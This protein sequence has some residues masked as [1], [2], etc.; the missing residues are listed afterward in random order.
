MNDMY[1]MSKEEAE[2]T[3]VAFLQ[4]II[5]ASNYLFSINH[6]EPYSYEG[7]ACGWLRYH[8][9]VEFLTCALNINKDNENKTLALTNYA[10]KIGI[11]IKGIKFGRS[12]FDYAADSVE[13]CIYKGL[14]GIKF[15]N[16][17]VSRELYALRNNHYSSAIALF[18]DILNN[19]SIN[20]RQMDILI[21]LGFFEDY[22]QPKKLLKQLEIYNESY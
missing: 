4:V 15:M 8:Y 21:K 1:G 6:S 14:G 16:E 10:N 13:K 17:T 12:L 3:I 11:P 18:D 7:Y 5:D 22:G 20:S 9:P 19:T 2:E